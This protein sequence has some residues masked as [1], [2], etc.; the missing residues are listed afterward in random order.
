[1]RPLLIAILLVASPHAIHAQSDAPTVEVQ[2]AAIQHVLSE[3]VEESSFCLRPA[4]R[5]YSYSSPSDSLDLLL[6]PTQDEFARLR[7]EARAAFG[8]RALP[9]CLSRPRTGFESDLERILTYRARSAERRAEGR[10]YFGR[11]FWKV[12]PYGEPAVQISISQPQIRD[13]GRAVI[14]VSYV[15]GSGSNS[16]RC[17]LRLEGSTWIVEDCTGFNIRA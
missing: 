13:D 11:T 2:L 14:G 8:P 1:V 15:R 6:A 9:Y 4:R 16:R 10:L 12:G 7:T 3:E 5:A 17:Q